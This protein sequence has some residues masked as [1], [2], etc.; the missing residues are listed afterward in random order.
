MLTS[1]FERELS[2]CT[3]VKQMFDVINKHYEIE[4]CRPGTI[5]K[6]TVINGLKTAIKMLNPKRR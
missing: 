2:S 5:T 3:T 6:A 4:N 1:E